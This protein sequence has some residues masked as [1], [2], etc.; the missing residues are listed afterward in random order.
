MPK[1][2]KSKYKSPTN[3]NVSYAIVE[4]EQEVDEWGIRIKPSMVIISPSLQDRMYTLTAVSSNG[5]YTLEL[6][7]K[8]AVYG[9]SVGQESYKDVVLRKGMSVD[10][11]TTVHSHMFMTE[12]NSRF[13]TVEADITVIITEYTKVYYVDTPISTD[14]RSMPYTSR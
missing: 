5:S 6:P 8:Q 13:A 7:L 14:V 12:P 1:I 4:Y 10:G 9:V 2:D 11:K 3:G